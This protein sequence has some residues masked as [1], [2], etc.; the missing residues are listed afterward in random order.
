MSSATEKLHFL[1]VL[2]I[3]K[4]IFGVQNK[5]NVFDFFFQHKFSI[6]ISISTFPNI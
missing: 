4:S 2:I 1:I 5:K 6:N 3:Q